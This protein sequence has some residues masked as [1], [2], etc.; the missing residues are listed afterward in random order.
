ML[1]LILM[2]QFNFSFFKF[3]FFKLKPCSVQNFYFIYWQFI[4]VVK[5]GSNTTPVVEWLAC[6]TLEILI[7]IV[8]LSFGSFML[9]FFYFFPQKVLQY[10]GYYWC[11]NETNLVYKK[12]TMRI[13]SIEF[14]Q[15]K[16]FIGC[17]RSEKVTATMIRNAS[18][19]SDHFI[20]GK[21]PHLT[22]E[23]T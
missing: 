10:S 4:S 20:S 23:L 1:Y 17:K 21:P 14:R 15:K 16:N 19:W 7:I 11:S 6:F 3:H 8:C 12:K 22:N 9:A 13:S 18:I 5:N 2:Y